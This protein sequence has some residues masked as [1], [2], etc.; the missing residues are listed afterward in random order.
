MTKAAISLALIAAAVTS[1]AMATAGQIPAAPAPDR[2]WSRV[3]ILE[4]GTAITVAMQGGQ[5]AE[6]VFVSA[7]MSRVT[8]LNLIDPALPVATARTLRQTASEHPEYFERAATGGTFL[9]GNVRLESGGVFVADRKILDLQR[10]VETSARPAVAQIT[11]R[12]KGRGVWGHLGPFGGYFVGAISGGFVTGLVC[13]AAAGRD[14]CDSGAFLTG[15]LVGG[16]AGAVYGLRAANRE[17]EAV[18][19]HAP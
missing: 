16:I 5:A 1:T 14:R 9:L 4:P 3:R 17:T 11:V 19:Y 8:V 12:Q 2:D 15:A 13:Q 7:D 6:R 10:L 18:I